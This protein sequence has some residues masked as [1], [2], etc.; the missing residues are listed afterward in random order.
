MTRAAWTGTTGSRTRG[1]G[2]T[3]RHQLGDKMADKAHDNTAVTVSGLAGAVQGIEIYA[4]ALRRILENPEFNS[5]R[6]PAWV[7][8]RRVVE[9]AVDLGDKLHGLLVTAHALAVRSRDSED[10]QTQKIH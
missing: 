7:E 1:R 2:N 10:I 3:G 9:E 5:I 4:Q 8:A 6:G